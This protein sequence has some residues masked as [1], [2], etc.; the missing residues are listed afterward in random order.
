MALWTKLILYAAYVGWSINAG[1]EVHRMDILLAGFSVSE[2]GFRYSDY[3]LIG[4]WSSLFRLNFR[5]PQLEIV[6]GLV[7]ATWAT[8]NMVPA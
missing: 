2:F 4:S 3:T 5:P 8:A 1:L 7:E 6:P